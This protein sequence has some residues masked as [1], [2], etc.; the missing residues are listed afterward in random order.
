MRV[1]PHLPSRPFTGIVTSSSGAA[2][3]ACSAAK[4][5]A[6]PAPRI[7]MSVSSLSK[8]P[9]RSPSLAG[10]LLRPDAGQYGRAP[11]RDF[12]LH[13]GIKRAAMCVH[14]DQQRPEALDAEAP[15]ALGI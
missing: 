2:F 3:L 8:P 5:P 6:P 4:S 13:A 11:R 15:E 9:P 1:Q 12:V 7:R 10:S 14:A